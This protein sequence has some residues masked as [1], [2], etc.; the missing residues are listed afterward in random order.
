MVESPGEQES[1]FFSVKMYTYHTPARTSG[2]AFQGERHSSPTKPAVG[3]LRAVPF[4]T[5]EV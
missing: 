5:A 4:V 3:M 1:S 2:P